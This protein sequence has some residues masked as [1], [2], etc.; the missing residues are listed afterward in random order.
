[1]IVCASVDSSAWSCDQG[2]DLELLEQVQAEGAEHLEQFE[3][4]QV[5]YL[6][7][8]ELLEKIPSNTSNA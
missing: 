4:V 3:W 8:L 6:E 2:I 1:M 5:G 7:P